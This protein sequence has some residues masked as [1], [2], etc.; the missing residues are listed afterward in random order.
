MSDS[1]TS[2]PLADMRAGTSDGAGVVEL[3]SMGIVNGTS[4][5]KDSTNG[6]E[7]AS[8]EGDDGEAR[9]RSTV[10]GVGGD[11][12]WLRLMLGS[13]HMGT[14]KVNA[15][16]LEPYRSYKI[17][18]NENDEANTLAR[19]PPRLHVS[20]LFACA[21][22][23]EPESSASADQGYQGYWSGGALFPGDG[24][25]Y[26]VPGGDGALQVLKVRPRVLALREAAASM[27]HTSPQHHAK[28]ITASATKLY[29]ITA[30]PQPGSLIP[31][32]RACLVSVRL[33][34]G[35]MPSGQGPC[36]LP[37]R[38]SASP[39]TS[40]RYSVLIRWLRRRQPTYA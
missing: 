4:E 14:V 24:N 12:E 18:V 25:I 34:S 30:W 37:V 1:I 11:E 33:K 6:T 28:T 19:P 7:H 22:E 36:M 16:Q 13:S 17:Q 23:E 9:G 29:V 35:R 39:A 38:Y 26:Y 2:S 40:A 8:D 27:S 32:E 10:V 20:T 15:E 3:R 5:E 21:H 31:L